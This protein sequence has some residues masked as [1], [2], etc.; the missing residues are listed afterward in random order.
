MNK[1]MSIDPSSISLDDI[2]EAVAEVI[3]RKG[4]SEIVTFKEVADYALEEKK[5]NPKIAA[6]LV[7]VKKNYDPQNE[8]DIFYTN[9]CQY[10][11]NLLQKY[12]KIGIIFE[13]WYIY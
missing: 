11:D 8:N 2:T 10:T 12:V 6:F 5:K 4:F 7:S 13:F 1:D 3:Y 9:N